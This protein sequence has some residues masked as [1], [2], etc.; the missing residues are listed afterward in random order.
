MTQR[1]RLLLFIA[2]ALAS[3]GAGFFLGVTEKLHYIIIYLSYPSVAAIFLLLAGSLVDAIRR[4]RSL[5]RF[6]PR[7]PSA[8]LAIGFV[9][10]MALL[11]EPYEF[12]IVNDELIL[13][14]IAQM[15]HFDG[16]SGMPRM[17]TDL[18]GSYELM[19]AI[20]DKRPLVF[21][22]ILSLIH[23][24]SGYRYENVFI[25]N[26]FLTGLLV[27]LI[28][29]VAKMLAGHRGGVLAVLLA[30]TLPLLA[31]FATS[32]H[33]EILNLV[34][35]CTVILFSYWYLQQPTGHRLVPLVYSLILLSQVRYENSLYLL[36]FGVLI[37]LGW[38]R[39][40]EIILPWP[41]IISPI[42][43]IIYAMHY[44]LILSNSTLAFQEGPNGRI[45][46]FS[47]SYAI[48]N[49]YS[50]VSYLFGIGQN[51]SNSYVLSVLGITAI[52][53]FCHYG[54]RK[55]RRM[56]GSNARETVMFFFL[57][58]G[59]LFSLVI[60]FFNFGVF[61]QY[62][63]NRLSFPLQLVFILFIPF[64]F[65]RYRAH[66]LLGVIVAGL[67]TSCLAINLMTRPTLLSKGIT[68]GIAVILFCGALYAIR[69]FKVRQFE[70]FSLLLLL[71]IFMITMPIAHAH[72]Y[73]Q[74]YRSNDA[75]NLALEFIGER[76]DKEKILWIS[77]I[78]YPA[79]LQEVGAF[80]IT[81]MKSDPARVLH[82][83]EH[84][85][86]S[87]VYIPRLFTY[88]EEEEGF[89]VYR[90]EDELDETIF[91]LEPVFE[92]PVKGGLL[93]RIDRLKAIH[94]DLPEEEED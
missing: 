77:Y 45:D 87:H 90:E 32:A 59:F 69:Y 3:L 51:S 72:R 47:T 92:F 64:I 38:R 1:E 2:T 18:S 70:R 35:L 73:T 54:L 19:D 26:T 50:A 36:P 22:F 52:G 44:R 20:L 84:R 21:P 83:I 15:V 79:L 31:S 60:T 75:A 89:K 49:L 81:R 40:G 71:H 43:F 67:A 13:S 27:T 12:R 91:E 85:N 86:Y 61:D 42:L 74:G 11:Y 7:R 58:A 23:D 41:V 55:S 14:A 10:F 53:F 63:T 24:L 48:E 46:T 66:Y 29:C 39:K 93:Y 57:M 33:F 34:V 16:L 94:L 78:P 68:F 62:I 5:V 37:L 25:L 17:A 88:M 82:Q 28:Y 76:K 56:T 9:T 80:P 65:R 4:D 30:G 6:L 8:F